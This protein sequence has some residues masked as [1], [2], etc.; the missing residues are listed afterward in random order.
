MFWSTAFSEYLHP[1]NVEGAFGGWNS[2]K[3]RLVMGTGWFEKGFL[4]QRVPYSNLSIEDTEWWFYMGILLQTQTVQYSG[5]LKITIHLYCL[6]PN[7]TSGHRHAHLLRLNAFLVPQSPWKAATKKPKHD[8]QFKYATWKGSMA[9]HSHVWVYQ[10]PLQIATFLGV[11]IAI[12]FHY[13]HSWPSRP[14]V[15]SVITS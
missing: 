4:P 2:I 8:E 11:A 14:S 6:I 1:Q 12:Y 10:S 15:E 5:S 13:F 7:L 9:S 3:I